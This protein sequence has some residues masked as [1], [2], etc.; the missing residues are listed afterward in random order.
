MP[1][2]WHIL[3]ELARLGSADALQAHIAS[4]AATTAMIPAVLP[5]PIVDKGETSFTF[6]GGKSAGADASSKKMRRTLAWNGDEAHKYEAV[7]GT[8][9]RISFT[10]SEGRLTDF[11]LEKSGP[12]NSRLRLSSRL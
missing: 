8:R 5:V 6:T 4:S 3:N 12:D 10:V 9:S 1:P 2:Q 11:A 7:P